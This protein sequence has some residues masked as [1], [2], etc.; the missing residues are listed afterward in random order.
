LVL[1]EVITLK[2]ALTII[3]NRAFFMVRNCTLH[4][5]GMLAVS[6]GHSVMADIL[7]SSSIFS[8]LTIA[9]YNSAVQCVVS[10]STDELD[11]LKRHLDNQ[12]HC[13][14]VNL[15]VPFAYHSPA[16]QPVLDDL[17]VV[18]KRHTFLPP[19]MPVLSGVYGRVI[20][21]G[22][23]SVF[24]AQYVVR[25]CAEPVLFDQA[26][27]ASLLIPEFANAAAWIE[28]GPD[29][30]CLS[31]IKSNRAFPSHLL[32]LG[33]L[34]KRQDVWIT[35][36]ESLAQLYLSS[37]N[38]LWQKPFVHIPS[39]LCSELPS[40]PFSS[41]EFWVDF[42]EGPGLSSYLRELE[43]H[44]SHLVLKY[45]LLHSWLQFPS[46]ANGRVAIFETPI[47][48]L[49]G[50]I[51]A[52][53]VGGS[54]LCPA[55]VYLEQVLAGI[56]LAKGHLAVTF[57]NDRV[58]LRSI[59]FIKPLVY[60]EH[61]SRT[62]KTSIT[63]ELDGLGTF[64][65][66]S[67]M[68]G[69]DEDS[70]HV[71]GYFRH[72][73]DKQIEKK[74]SRCLP[75]VR[76]QLAA[77]MRPIDGTPP[78]TFLVRTIYELIF[79]RVVDYGITYR[80]IQ[81]LTVDVNG[82]EGSAIIKLPIGNGGK[83]K[84]V[85]HPAFMDSLFHVA[86]F[87]ANMKCDLNVAYICNAVGSM[88][89]NPELVDETAS[90]AIYCCNVW[91]PEEGIMLADTYALQL[92]GPQRIVAHL[93]GL[94]FRRVRFDNFKR[95]LS[96]AAGS[97]VSPQY[98]NS[99]EYSIPTCTTKSPAFPAQRPFASATQNQILSAEVMRVVS[100]TCDID[101]TTF[102]VHTDLASLG[103][104]SLLSIEIF[105]KLRR[106]F[107]HTRLDAQALAFCHTIA[108]IVEEL[109]PKPS[110]DLAGISSSSTLISVADPVL[111]QAKVML[112][113]LPVV[114]T[115]DIADQ[116]DTSS[117]APLMS[118]EGIYSV[119][120]NPA[121]DISYSRFRTHTTAGEGQLF[122]SNDSSKTVPGRAAVGAKTLPPHIDPES[123]VKAFRL[124][125]VPVPI[126]KSST[127]GHIPLFLIH[128]GSGLISYYDRL[129]PLDR[130]VWGIHN[131]HFVNDVPWPWNSL[132]SMAT[133]YANYVLK[134]TSDSVLIG[135]KG[136]I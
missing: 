2:G 97:V 69:S 113:S 131:P 26:I 132:V 21:P 123:I 45:S 24:N 23:G 101:S 52:H 135:G 74:L 65:V 117:V 88:H 61:V 67:K 103:V 16:M 76:R 49:A 58:I 55:S 111:D 106:V 130:D 120:D 100:Q 3:A 39:A 38:V 96:L 64:T 109:C 43:C 110:P 114:C 78:E 92:T 102:D 73:S 47:E 15:A 53:T 118:T 11:A 127:V 62:V 85:A 87:I 41:T 33:T 125:E 128:D 122:I 42:K 70:V 134:V 59:E 83:T 5:S 72:K 54:H 90:Y 32:L 126:Q 4:N 79:P 35:L 115:D 46:D 104:D 81:S 80:T 37:V 129:S 119:K 93:K 105:D 68:G 12:T 17:L 51:R 86:G 121:H 22:D 66:S 9:C 48:C 7:A 6:L 99:V 94:Q 77:V 1:A 13:K 19:T 31:M 133:E 50:F 108:E 30:P 56:D 82:M 107:P 57:L 124:G 34:R 28:L 84:F 27:S 8:N 60:I 25:Q 136:S 112:G 18:A 29:V 14:Y 98:P 71:H 20:L 89:I 95:G 116:M 40:Y 10:G 36:S 44:P 75:F 91:L 63:F